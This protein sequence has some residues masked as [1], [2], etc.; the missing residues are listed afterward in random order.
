[1]HTG[2]RSADAIDAGGVLPGYQGVIVRDGYAGYSH[3]TSAL[4]AWCGVHRLRDLKDLYDFEP[5]KQDWASQMAS[6]PIEG[7]RRRH[8]RPPGREDSAGRRRPD[9]HPHPLPGT[10]CQRSRRERLPPDRDVER[11][12]TVIGGHSDVA[13]VV[14]FA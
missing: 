2:D 10:G 6:L 8:G 3:L 12:G 13:P 9:R 4:H 5:W 1:L 14:E 7:S 11:P